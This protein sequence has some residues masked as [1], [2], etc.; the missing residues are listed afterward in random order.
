[1]S[2]GAN[3]VIREKKPGVWEYAIQLWP[4]GESDKYNVQGPFKSEQA[5]VDHMSNNNANPGGWSTYPYKE[6]K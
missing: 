3:C 4:Y 5:A 1:M 6:K 2:T